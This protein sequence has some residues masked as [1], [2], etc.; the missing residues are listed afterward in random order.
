MREIRQQLFFPRNHVE[1]LKYAGLRFGIINAVNELFSLAT[2]INDCCPT[3]SVTMSAE[4][5]KF[6]ARRKFSSAASSSS[7]RFQ[8][9]LNPTSSICATL[10]LSPFSRYSLQSVVTACGAV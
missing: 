9:W 8:N 6:F 4:K 1:Q 5:R 2:S 3:T 7:L 10:N